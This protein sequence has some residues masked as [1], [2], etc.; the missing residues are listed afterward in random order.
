[1]EIPYI[2]IQVPLGK[3]IDNRWSERTPAM[4]GFFIM[5]LTT[6]IIA[7]ATDVTSALFWCILLFVQRIGG[8]MS[9]VCLESYFFKHV[10]VAEQEE[11]AAFRALYPLT[12]IVGPLCA[13]TLLLFGGYS[14]V[15]FALSMLMAVAVYVSFNLED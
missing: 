15:F 12:F 6:G 11:V 2:L 10:K 9:E 4:I 7:L 14:A 5:A 1:M 8:A 3:M 13:S